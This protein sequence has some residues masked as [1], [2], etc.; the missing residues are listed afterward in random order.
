[1]VLVAAT[2]VCVAAMNGTASGS[3]SGSNP[4]VPI[5]ECV[6]HVNGTSWLALWGYSNSSSSTQTIPIGSGNSFSP[7]AENQG[8][9]T[10]FQP[11]TVNNLFTAPFVASEPPA[12]T[13]DGTTVSSSPS[14]KKCPSDPVPMIVGAT[15]WS[16]ELPLIFVAIGILVVG[17]CSWRIDPSMLGLHRTGRH[18]SRRD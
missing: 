2:G 3:E 8:Q 5:L 6:W 16:G 1:M 12:W 18:R 9:P 14:D 13:L 11:G 7:G 4:V 17:V 10:A 15:G